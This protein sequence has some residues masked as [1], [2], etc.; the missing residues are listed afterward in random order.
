MAVHGSLENRTKF[1]QS[2][3]N[4]SEIVG[5]EAMN[6]VDLSLESQKLIDEVVASGRFPNREAALNEAVRLLSIEHHQNGTKSTGDLSPEEW[7]ERFER[8]ARGH[9]NVDHE[10]DDSRDSIYEGRGE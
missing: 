2:K 8:W 4:A 5:N 1:S 7:C 10:A 6:M 3:S 9:A